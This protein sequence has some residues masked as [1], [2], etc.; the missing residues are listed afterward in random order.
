MEK[1]KIKEVSASVSMKVNLG[2][3]Q[4]EDVF[5][6]AVAEVLDRDPKEVATAVYQFCKE[7]AVTERNKI[8]S[9]I[10]TSPEAIK[11]SP[12]RFYKK[13]PSEAVIN[14][15]MEKREDEGFRWGEEKGK[16]D[17]VQ[18]EPKIQPYE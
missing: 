9:D 13:Q 14:K 6:S 8:V 10:K 1:I 17:R 3:Y 2:N 4:T 11:P 12:K 16:D 5:F 7:L 18:D 15:N